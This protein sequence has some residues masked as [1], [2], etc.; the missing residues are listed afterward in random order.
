MHIH[1]H[2]HTQ[3]H[4]HFHNDSYT[5]NG[6]MHKRRHFST[7]SSHLGKSQTSHQFT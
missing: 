6:A 4:M 3:P 5:L 7:A 2:I 1:M